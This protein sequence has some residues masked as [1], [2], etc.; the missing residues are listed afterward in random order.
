MYIS[1]GFCFSAG[2]KSLWSQYL[3]LLGNFAWYFKDTSTI[4]LRSLVPISVL[5]YHNNK[6]LHFVV[7]AVQMDLVCP[8]KNINRIPAACFFKKYFLFFILERLCFSK[9]SLWLNKRFVL[10]FLKIS[11]WTLMLSILKGYSCD[12]FN[13]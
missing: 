1:L 5:H 11:T 10:C 12:Y 4:S 13:I 7:L 2:K 8:S 9:E 6:S 3:F